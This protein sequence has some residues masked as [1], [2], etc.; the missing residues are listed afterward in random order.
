MLSLARCSML[1]LSMSKVSAGRVQKLLTKY[2]DFETIFKQLLKNEKLGN[3]FK[4]LHSL[5]NIKILNEYYQKFLD[6]NIK[7]LFYDD[8]N[9]PYLLKNIDSPP[10]LLYYAGRL[11]S[12]LLPKVGIVGT[13]N[14]SSYGQEVSTII[15]RDLVKNG[16]CIVSGLAYGVDAAAHRSALEHN[17]YTIGNLLRDIA[18][19]KGLILSEYPPDTSPAAYHFPHRNRI[20]SGLSL[21]IV[22]V[23]GK[24]KSGGMIT[25]NEA[26][27][28]GREVFAIPGR[29]GATM[30]EGTNT[31]LRE[32][33]ILATSANDILQE[34]GLMNLEED[35]KTTQELLKDNLSK[36]IVQL[37][38]KEPL[39]VHEISTVLKINE[40][41]LLEKLPILEIQ[42]FIHREND[43]RYTSS[44]N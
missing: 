27:K 43:N 42:G 17:G 16:V 19:N 35:N 31:I 3:N 44:I 23:E 10:Y 22:F 33:A 40:E 38:S 1:W 2:G 25:V 13:R 36:Q 26:L 21:G 34:L 39:F 20:I 4:Q 28:Q 37:L 12:L 5:H 7:F 15:A 9:Y 6:N 30:S 8:E 29:I 18:K 24:I 14:P 32:G 41:I 11:D